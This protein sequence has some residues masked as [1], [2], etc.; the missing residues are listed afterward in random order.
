M[1]AAR[2]RCGC[3]ATGTARSSPVEDDGRGLPDGAE[4]M[5]FERFWRADQA[6]STP[7]NG[8]GLSIVRSAVEA[9]GGSVRAENRPE[10]GA[11]F[12]VRL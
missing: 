3:G 4:D 1:G 5:V 12:T 8:I 6:R 7:G 10:G 11:R 2:S 9:H